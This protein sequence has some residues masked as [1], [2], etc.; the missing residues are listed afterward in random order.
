M[1]MELTV[2]SQEA[3]EAVLHIVTSLAPLLEAAEE[4]V[5]PGW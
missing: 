3:V 2:Q 5:P 1:E 4:P